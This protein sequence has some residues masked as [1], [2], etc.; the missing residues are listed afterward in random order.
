VILTAIAAVAAAVFS[1]VNVVL[2]YRQA[3]RGP[4]EQWRREQERPVV[5]RV[6]TLSSDLTSN[7]AMLVF[8]KERWAG[9]WD[10]ELRADED[11]TARE[12]LMAGMGLH[13][14]LQFEA[15]QL[16]LL[17]SPQ[18]RKAAHD[19]ATAHSRIRHGIIRFQSD[20]AAFRH[21]QESGADEFYEWLVEQARADLGLGSGFQVPPRS[22]LARLLGRDQDGVG[23]G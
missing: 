7:W 3:R 4:R 22:V 10:E 12:Q 1:G 8:T 11:R 18:V 20:P 21:G 6:L 14:K 2:S 9:A 13:G 15:A 19:L 17:A 23:M 5:A 16:D